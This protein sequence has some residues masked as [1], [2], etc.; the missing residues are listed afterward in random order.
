MI[1]P[2]LVEFVKIDRKLNLLFSRALVAIYFWL[3]VPYLRPYFLNIRGVRL[4]LVA[5]LMHL[6]SSVVIVLSPSAS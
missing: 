5:D 1:R 3:D 2:L 6:L 4:L